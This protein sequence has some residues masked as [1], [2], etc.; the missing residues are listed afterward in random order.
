MRKNKG[1]QAIEL[2]LLLALV[3]L[4]AITSMFMFG[5]KVS[6]LFGDSSV[7]FS[8]T[9]IDKISASS[10]PTFDFKFEKVATP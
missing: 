6:S 2:A 7:V 9:Q 1:Q 5:D 3:T 10:Q 8:S 4:A